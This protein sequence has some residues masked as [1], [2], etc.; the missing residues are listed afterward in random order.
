VSRRSS[1]NAISARRARVAKGVAIVLV[2]AAAGVSVAA[3]QERRARLVV[4]RST[5]NPS[6]ATL[7]DVGVTV[8]ND[9]L[10]ATSYD[11]LIPF[12]ADAFEQARRDGVRGAETLLAVV[13]RRAL[14]RYLWPPPEGSVLEPQW[15]AM[16]KDVAALFET[17][18]EPVGRA[19]R[20]SLRIV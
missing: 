5:S 18:P 12:L 16:V 19:D 6:T 15:R 8:E 7:P 20:G 11:K 14:P 9:R 13:M 4:V 10:V 2:G 1:R 3:W 17:D